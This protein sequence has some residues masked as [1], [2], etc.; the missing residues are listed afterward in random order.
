MPL[1]KVRKVMKI[2][3]GPSSLETP[4]GDEE[5]SHLGDFIEDKNAVIPVDAA[6][7]ANLKETVTRV[8][9][10]LT[11]REERVLRMRF[12]IGMNT[13]HTLEEVGQQFSVTRERIRQIEAKAL[14]KLKHPSRSRKMR[15]FLDQYG[16]FSFC[17]EKRGANP[18]PVTSYL[19]T[20]AKPVGDSEFAPCGA[21]HRNIAWIANWQD[22]RTPPAIY[23]ICGEP[24][25]TSMVQRATAIHQQA[26]RSEEQTSELQSLMRNAHAASC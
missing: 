12:G 5:D 13:D 19:H 15:S 9:A 4:I 3:K 18:H 24:L 22:G 11:P 21:W 10:S 7:Q 26:G 25:P 6:I 23:P 14:R 16:S 1:E 2:A 8:L 20:G 17:Y